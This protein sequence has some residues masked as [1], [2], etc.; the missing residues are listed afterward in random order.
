MP[1]PNFPMRGLPNPGG[2]GSQPVGSIGSLG[3]QTSPMPGTPQSAK[4]GAIGPAASMQPQP[5]GQSPEIAKMVADLV[6]QELQRLG[7]GGPT[8]R[9]RSA[10]HQYGGGESQPARGAF[11]S[12]RSKGPDTG[13]RV[14]VNSGSYNTGVN[15]NRARQNNAGGPMGPSFGTGTSST[16]ASQIGP[17]AARSTPATPTGDPMLAQRN[18]EA[19]SFRYW[20]DKGDLDKAGSAFDRKDKL[21]QILGMGFYGGMSTFT[22]EERAKV[23]G[24]KKVANDLPPAARIKY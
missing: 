24:P 14:N 20:T 22:P 13:S 21:D 23:S 11:N 17:T 9:P 15:A 6:T 5:M 4:F 10:D 19:A 2:A 1:I 8:R 12:Y 16:G 7:I 18:M 3:P